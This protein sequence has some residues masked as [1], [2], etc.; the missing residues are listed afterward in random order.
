MSPGRNVAVGA[1]MRGKATFVSSSALYS[2]LFVPACSVDAK[3]AHTPLPRMANAKYDGPSI[4]M[5]ASRLNRIVNVERADHRL[6]PGPRDAEERLLVAGLQVPEG[7]EVHEL[8]V[9]PQLPDAERRPA[10]RASPR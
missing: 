10:A 6:D 5:S 7:E 2:R 3:Y 8:A 9:G 1:T 4:S